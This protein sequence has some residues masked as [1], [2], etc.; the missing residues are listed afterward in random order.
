MLVIGTFR[1][2]FTADR[3]HATIS[4]VLNLIETMNQESEEMLNHMRIASLEAKLESL[5][6]EN[7][8]LRSELDGLRRP[9]WQEAAKQRLPGEDQEDRCGCDECE[10]ERRKS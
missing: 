4:V 8:V 10:K 7:A 6:N 9:P 2:S 1:K 5:Q 3:S